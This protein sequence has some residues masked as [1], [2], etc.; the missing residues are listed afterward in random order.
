MAARAPRYRPLF[1]TQFSAASLLQARTA[2]HGIPGTVDKAAVAAVNKTLGRM[3]T[4]VSQGLAGPRG[5]LNLKQSNLKR[6][7][8]VKKASKG[9]AYGSLKIM[10]RPIG[11]VNFNAKDT[12]KSTYDASGKGVFASVIR[13]GPRVGAYGR[14]GQFND[15]N[16]AFIAEGLNG[17]QHV[18][19][20]RADARLPIDTMF[21]QRLYDLFKE[22]PVPNK[23]RE[24]VP[25]ELDKQL[26]SQ[27]DRFLI[28][29]LKKKR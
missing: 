9:N 19:I 28:Q 16:Y 3:R 6:R 15:L 14:N 23:L 13:G 1:E 18:F 10:G 17:N 20:R 29:G 4:Q 7:L 8:I 24:F 22:S 27:I 2:L 12:R 26:R 21:S 5:Y 25:D 11:L